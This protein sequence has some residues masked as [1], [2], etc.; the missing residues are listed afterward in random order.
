MKRKARRNRSREQ[1]AIYIGPQQSAAGISSPLHNV[2]TSVWQPG[3]G[4]GIRHV[5]GNRRRELG[6]LENAD[7]PRQQGRHDM[8][9]RQVPWEVEGSDHGHDAMRAM[10]EFDRTKSRTDSLMP[11]AFCLRLDRNSDL[12]YHGVHFGARLPQ[13]FAHIAADRYCNGFATGR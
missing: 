1:K 2:E 7:V 6:W 8:A 5:E 12:A 13:G 9:I 3:F 10:T 11:R 4:E